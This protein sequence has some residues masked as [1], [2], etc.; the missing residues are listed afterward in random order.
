MCPCYL[1]LASIVAESQ[2]KVMNVSNEYLL[3]FHLHKALFLKYFIQAEQQF[4]LPKS[5]FCVHFPVQPG[6]FLINF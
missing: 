3:T 4:S 1:F 6:K 2:N 5:L